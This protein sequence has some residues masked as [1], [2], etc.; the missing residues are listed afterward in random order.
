METKILDSLGN[1]LFAVSVNGTL[2]L[3]TVTGSNRVPY[4]GAIKFETQ[5][6]GSGC[7][8]NCK[9]IAPTFSMRPTDA[10]QGYKNGTEYDHQTLKD[11]LNFGDTLPSGTCPAEKLFIFCIDAIIACEW[12]LEDGWIIDAII[13]IPFAQCY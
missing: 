12:H 9:G 2:K 1:E 7:D 5:S 4:T 13:E 10:I 8:C 6:G 11:A 3:Y